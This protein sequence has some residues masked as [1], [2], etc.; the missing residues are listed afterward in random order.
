[1]RTILLA[2]FLAAGLLAGCESGRAAPAASQQAEPSAKPG[3]S[4]VS[5]APAASASAPAAPA[6]VEGTRYGAGITVAEDAI[7]SI[8]A[9]LADPEAY[10]GKT[11]RVEGMVTDVCPKRGCWMDLAGQGAGQKVRLKVQDGVMTFPMEAKGQTAVAQ[12]TVAVETLSLEQSREYA[13]YQAREYGA[14][15]DPASITEPMKIVR[16]DGTGA[17]IRAPE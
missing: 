3:A 11:V 9:L 4:A 13:A 17:V 12:G 8:D 7:V 2:S 6:S 16:I 14:A 10:Q 5:A 15:I 1:M